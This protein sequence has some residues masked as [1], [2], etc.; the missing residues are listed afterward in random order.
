VVLLTP[1]PVNKL[2]LLVAW[3]TRS[4]VDRNAV[5][6][7]LTSVVQ[8]EFALQELDFRFADEDDAADIAVL[9]MTLICLTLIST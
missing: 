7:W 1:L 9:V 4:N 6:V 5:S 3:T 8:M 2:T